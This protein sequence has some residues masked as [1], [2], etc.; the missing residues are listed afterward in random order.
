MDWMHIGYA[1]MHERKKQTLQYLQ[2]SLNKIGL[3][4]TFADII[5]FDQN[6]LTTLAETFYGLFRE[7][8]CAMLIY[9]RP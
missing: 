9:R 2:N 7:L 1:K 4:E 6:F 5:G 3:V 8:L